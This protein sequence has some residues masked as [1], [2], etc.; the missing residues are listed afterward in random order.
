MSQDGS[1]T[2]IEVSKF[3]E[4]RQTQYGRA[5][6]ASQDI[7]KGVEI[8]ISNSPFATVILHEFRKEVCSSCFGYEYG[9]YCKVKLTDLPEFKSN[10]KFRGAGLWFCSEKCMEDWLKFDSK[11]ELTQAFETFLEFYQTKTKS[12][13]PETTEFNPKITTEYIELYWK[14]IED[15]ESKASKMKKTKL[16]GKLPYLDEDEYTGARL[17]IHALYNIYQ[18]HESLETFKELQTNELQK[19]GRFP[20]LLRSQASIYQVLKTILPDYLQPFLTIE[21]IRLIFGREYGN[22]FGTWQLVDDK[23]SENKEFLGYS[24]FP[25]ASFF[26]HS[27]S[28]N[29]KKYRK[30]NRMHFQTTAD[31]AKGEQMCIDY[32]HM[33]DESLMV[34]QEVLSKNWFFECACD[35]CDEEF[36]SE[37]YQVKPPPKQIY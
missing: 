1:P 23:S 9:K 32:F 33:L 16:L 15:W 21:T 36:R 29:L 5:C 24:L 37:S 25:E 18:N 35:R 2:G 13:A 10:K 19:V 34:R 14:D 11:G 6:F 4:V 3:F 28:P 12:P 8:L 27:C 22:S 26:N 7:P 17:I 30:V 31:I 20:A